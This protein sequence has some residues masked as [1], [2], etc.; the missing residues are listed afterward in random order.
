MISKRMRWAI[1]V[2]VA[3]VALLFLLPPM[4]KSKAR[5]QRIGSVNHLASATITLPATNAL[6]PVTGNK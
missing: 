5:A 6:P 1:I 4:P 3:V 2:L